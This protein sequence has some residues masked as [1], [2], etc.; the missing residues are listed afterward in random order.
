MGELHRA[1]KIA[2]SFDNEVLRI[3]KKFL[4]AGFP[5][6]FINS[7]VEDFTKSPDEEPLTPIWLFDDNLV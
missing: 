6:C 7:V 1:S 3:K 4:S 2:S 5:I